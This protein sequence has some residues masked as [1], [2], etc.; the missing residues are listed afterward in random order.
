MG[1]DGVELVMAVEEEFGVSIAD[2]EA[3]KRLH[4]SDV[5]DLVCSKVR[6]TGEQLCQSQRS[7]YIARRALVQTFGV[8]REAAKPASHLSD[9]IPADNQT[10]HWN[11]LKLAMAAEEW[12]KLVRPRWMSIMIAVI[13]GLVSLCVII[14]LQWNISSPLSLV[15]IVVGLMAA[16]AFSKLCKRIT[17]RWENLIPIYTGTVLD[18]ARV[19][20]RSHDM[21]WTRDGIAKTL[22]RI[23][24][25]Q[26]GLKEE[27][28]SEDAHFVK[29]YGV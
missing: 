4:P 16:I 6:L 28:Y 18:L 3:E 25:D 9:F 11:R 15:S 7:F 2:G 19:A 23:I 17:R 12:P 24:I 29:D 14:I 21:E 22:K 26:L 8:Q 10:I 1:L 13:S 27:D 5:I 20:Q